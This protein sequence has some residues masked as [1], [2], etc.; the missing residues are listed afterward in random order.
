MSRNSARRNPTDQNVTV[1]KNRIKDLE[2]EV[3]TLKAR[4]DELRKAKNNTILKRE[5]E[6]IHVGEPTLGRP[7]GVETSKYKELEKKLSDSEAR[8]AALKKELSDFKEE[9]KNKDL[10]KH[11][12]EEQSEM[13]KKKY[14]ELEADVNSLQMNHEIEL[15][16]CKAKVRE[17][18]AEAEDL[19]TEL[20]RLRERLEIKAMQEEHKGRENTDREGHITKLTNENAFLREK[21]ETLYLEL[22][23]KEAQWTEREEKYKVEIKKEWGEKYGVWMAATEKRLKELHEANEMLKSCLYKGERKHKDNLK[24]FDEDDEKDGESGSSSA[25]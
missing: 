15:G 9:L 5:R 20:E 8:Y 17:K 14:Q 7:A 19:S 24:G 18:T 10:A 23:V 1:L 4:L 12:T 22:S 3:G 25:T 6:V 2:G 13:W 21:I 11:K 16:K